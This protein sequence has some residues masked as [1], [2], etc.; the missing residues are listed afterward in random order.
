MVKDKTWMYIESCRKFTGQEFY[1][2][3]FIVCANDQCEKAVKYDEI[4]ARFS[5]F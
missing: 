1:L 2:L 5:Q 3:L 4:L